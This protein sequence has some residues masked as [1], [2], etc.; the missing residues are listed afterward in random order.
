MVMSGCGALRYSST[1]KPSGDKELRFGQARFSLVDFSTAYAK[2][3]P[4]AE[5]WMKVIDRG[6][7]TTRAKTLYPNLFTDDWT[8]LPLMVKADVT[9][10]DSSIMTS[11]FVTA[12]TAGIVPFPGATKLSFSVVTNVRDAVGD[13][14]T[15]K[16]VK[17]VLEQGMWISLVGPLGCIPV[18]GQADLPRDGLL[19]FI[20]LTKDAYSQTKGPYYAADCI[21]EAMVQALRSVEPARLEAA[22][23]ARQSRL[24]EV[25]VDGKRY[26]CFLAPTLTQ[27]HERAGLF[28]ALLYQD[29]PKRGV[30]PWA[31]MTVARR[32]EAG[33]W[34]PVAGYLRSAKTLTTISAL[35]ED[36][37]PAKV[38]VRTIEEPPLEDFLDTPDLSVP[39]RA[40]YLRWS[41]GV[42]LE[43]KN[44]SLPKV[45]REK[46][47]AE[48][49][50][51]VTRIEKAILDLNEQAEQ[52]KDRAQT[53]VEKGQ[54]DPAQDRELAIL[55]RQRIE[56]LKPILVAIKQK[57][58]S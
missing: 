36:G 22:Y 20:P 23:G 8:G 25:M 30:Q 53:K 57:I 24:Q 49:L 28:T 13:S 39:D 31:E 26:W 52:A 18:P 5:T 12:L 34:Q 27:Q 21:V 54:G 33:V 10:D 40:E 50:S 32:D 48:L 1:L 43:A 51:L 9:Y 56:V 11:A 17:F 2:N 6:L 7:V 55:C 19:L 16:D 3:N 45:L 29:Y 14:L 4:G 15:D 58:A 42:L 46:S 41:N 35:L 47:R 38:A 44:R 37:V